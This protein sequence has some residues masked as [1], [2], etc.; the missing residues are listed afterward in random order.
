MRPPY[1]SDTRATLFA[2]PAQE[3]M[4]E[5]ATGSVD[6]IVTSPPILWAL[7]A[8]P[9]WG[10]DD[11][12]IS[13]L[14]AAMR[15][16]FGPARRILTPDGTLWLHIP[17]LYSSPSTRPSVASGAGVHGGSLLG[18]PW[19][20]ATGLS[21]DGWLIRRTIAWNIADGSPGGNRGDHV[22]GSRHETILLLAKSPTHYLTQPA[23]QRPDRSSGR[24][25]GCR[26]PSTRH[27]ACGVQPRAGC[28]GDLWTVEQRGRRAAFDPLPAAVARRCIAVGCRPGG[29]VLDPFTQGGTVALA[30]R[31]QHRHF[32]GCEAHPGYLAVARRRLEKYTPPHESKGTCS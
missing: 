2:G 14:V 22:L 8:Q 12:M 26:T 4:R 29:T 11:Q 28:A 7:P 27:Y 5:F 17:D 32:I 16:V 31:Q 3:M 6:C 1:W 23:G 20:V 18:L 25:G 30:A 10:G 19:H 21:A 13:A 15:R 24:H 9:Y